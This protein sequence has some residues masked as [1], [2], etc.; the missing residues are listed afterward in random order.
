MSG[1]LAFVLT[2]ALC[3]ASGCIKLPTAQ[4]QPSSPGE[5]FDL[6]KLKSIALVNNR[7][8]HIHDRSHRIVAVSPRPLMKLVDALLE[9]LDA[10]SGS[11]S[12]YARCLEQAAHLW[13][14]SDS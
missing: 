14:S 7:A 1:Y 4:P 6:Q 3:L 2:L 5:E 9:G 8:R 12:Q 10:E 13:D 11:G